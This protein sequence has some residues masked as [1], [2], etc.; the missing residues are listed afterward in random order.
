MVQ[1]DNMIYDRLLRRQILGTSAEEDAKD[2]KEKE[3][4]SKYYN[5]SSLSIMEM[6]MRALTKSYYAALERIKMLSEELR[7][8]KEEKK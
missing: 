5:D 7:L 4:H 3:N 1:D 8:I 2:K 6:D